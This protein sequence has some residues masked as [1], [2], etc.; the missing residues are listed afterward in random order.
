MKLKKR[1]TDHDH[2]NKY[3][4]TQGF[5]KLTAQKFAARLVQANLESKNDIANFVKKTDFDDKLKNLNK[6]NTSNK[7]KHALFENEFKKL[8]TFDSSLFIN[9]SHFFIDG[10]QLYIIF[11][12]I[13]YTLKKLGDNEKVVLWKSKGFSDKKLATPTT[14]DNSL[15]P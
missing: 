12:T 2:S 7:I 14:T 1:I 10:A 5:D 9:Q 15:F 4:A 8:Q 6:K 3:V 13:Y 11:P